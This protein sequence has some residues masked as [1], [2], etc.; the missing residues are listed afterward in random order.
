MTRINKETAMLRTVRLA[1]AVLALMALFCATA[2]AESW[3]KI[4]G[5][6]LYDSDDGKV[7]SHYFSSWATNKDT[8]HM[9]T[10]GRNAGIA[11]YFNYVDGNK[12]VVGHV[13]E[14]ESYHL[15]GDNNPIE[16]TFHDGDRRQVEVTNNFIWA[17]ARM[18]TFNFKTFDEK[19]GRDVLY[20][21]PSESIK[22]LYFYDQ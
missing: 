13:I 15:F 18:D 19:L 9:R 17:I 2:L 12:R 22:R 14:A 16:I 11:G 1:V 20:T 8:L 5:R 4:P 10:R 6:I 3:V 7:V 21:V